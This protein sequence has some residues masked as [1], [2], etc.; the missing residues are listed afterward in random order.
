MGKGILAWETDAKGSRVGTGAISANN[1]AMRI[2][3]LG[4]SLFA[5]PLAQLMQA[6]LCSVERGE[7]ATAFR[8]WLLILSMGLAA[9][10]SGIFFFRLTVIRIVYVRGNFTETELKT[11]AA[12]LPA[13]LGYLIVLSLNA[14]LARYLFTTSRGTTYVRCMISAYIAANLLRIAVPATMSTSLIIWCSVIAEGCAMVMSFRACLRERDE[15]N[16]IALPNTQEVCS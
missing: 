14:F 1:Y 10:G 15:R 16:L 4:Y 6:R 7:R 12:L 5:Q 9:I 3:M 8:R 2:G 13:W 11:V